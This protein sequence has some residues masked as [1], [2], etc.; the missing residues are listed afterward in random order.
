MTFSET[1]PKKILWDLGALRFLQ[2]VASECID[3]KK[4]QN[5]MSFIIFS[6]K[7]HKIQRC[8]GHLRAPK[9]YIFTKF[10]TLTPVLPSKKVMISI[11]I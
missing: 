10:E 3:N 4:V 2:M 5:F 11:Q 8:Q 9:S 7:I 6:P 1:L